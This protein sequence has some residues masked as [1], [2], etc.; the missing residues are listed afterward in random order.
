MSNPDIRR[1]AQ[2]GAER[3]RCGEAATR[4]PARP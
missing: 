2:R 4:H 3:Q 1:F